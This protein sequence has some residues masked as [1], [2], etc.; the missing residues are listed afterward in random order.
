MKPIL[1]PSIVCAN[2]LDLRQTLEQMNEIGIE[3]LHLD[4]MDNSFVHGFGLSPSLVKQIKSVSKA[5]LDIHLMT[6]LC[7]T[8]FDEFYEAGADRIILH[9]EC[10]DFHSSFENAIRGGN[11]IGIAIK[12]ATDLE[13]VKPYLY[14]IDTLLVFTVEPGL[15]GQPIL[16]T[17]PSRVSAAFA[18][19]QEV[20]AKCT[21][22]VDGGVYLDSI[23]TLAA[24]G[25]TVFVVGSSFFG[26]ANI[27]DEN[28]QSSASRLVEFATQGSTL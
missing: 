2:F 8:V 27:F 14:Y 17:A 28:L 5:K 24:A 25:A 10:E 23:A 1:A 9:A 20:G 16:P 18:M 7:D 19:I 22:Q 26:K 3:L 4:V 6:T 11:S 12:P 15:R 13:L 21:L